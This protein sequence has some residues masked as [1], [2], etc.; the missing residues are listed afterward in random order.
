RVGTSPP[1]GSPSERAR[2]GG[3]LK[4]PMSEANAN[5]AADT[6]SPRAAGPRAPESSIAY[7][8]NAVERLR[9]AFPGE[10]PEPTEFRGEVSLVVPRERIRALC[11]WLKREAKFD[12]LTDLS[13][14]DHYGEEPRFE[15]AYVLCA[16]SE[17]AHLRLKT[18]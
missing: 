12:M 11:S 9:A 2:A 15:V 16:L 13:C 5:G 1:A 8:L 18:K 6:T 14:V 3:R 4:H 17:A 7:T 10:L